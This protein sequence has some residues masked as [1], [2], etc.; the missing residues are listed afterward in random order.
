MFAAPPMLSVEISGVVV[1][2]SSIPE[3][4][5]Y[6]VTGRPTMVRMRPQLLAGELL[7]E[8]VGKIPM[9]VRET[10]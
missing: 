2:R 6:D 10:A 5:L 7:V 3:V 9:I 1:K 8:R 4:V